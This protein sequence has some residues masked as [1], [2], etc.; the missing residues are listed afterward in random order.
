MLSFLI[1]V[2]V[3][4]GLSFIFLGFNIFFRRKGFPETEVGRNKEMR[5]MGLTCPKCDN[6]QNNRKL[7]SAV[8]INPEKLRIVNS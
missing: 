5:K 6:I 8:R 7:K 4:V 1:V 3:I 2:L